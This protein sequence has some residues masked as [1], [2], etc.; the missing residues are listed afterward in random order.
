MGHMTH[1]RNPVHINK[2]IIDHKVDLESR[3]QIISFVIIK[4]SLFVKPW[5]HF[6]QGCFVPSLV[7]I[8]QCVLRR[9]WK[10][11]KFTDGQ[12]DGRQTT[13]NKKSSLELSARRAKNGRGHG[14]AI[15][16]QFNLHVCKKFTKNTFISLKLHLMKIVID[17][18]RWTK[19][20]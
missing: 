8:A 13:G 9:K 11:D 4:W 5:A 7:E 16:I 18:P 10:C 2:H 15:M 19:W 3:N 12:T 1:R 20:T 14:Q 17:G 6:T